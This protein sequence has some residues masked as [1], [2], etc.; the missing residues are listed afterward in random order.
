MSD[1]KFVFF[2]QG[3]FKTGEITICRE[4][5]EIQV[6]SDLEG[7]LILPRLKDYLKFLI[8]NPEWIKEF[9]NNIHI[10]TDIT[11]HWLYYLRFIPRY[12]IYYETFNNPLYFDNGVKYPQVKKWIPYINLENIYKNDIYE[13][14]IHSSNVILKEMFN[15]CVN[16]DYTYFKLLYKISK[17]TLDLLVPYLFVK[18]KIL[19]ISHQ[20][21]VR[22]FCE[23]E[24]N[25]ILCQKFK[26]KLAIKLSGL[27]GENVSLYLITSS[28]KDYLNFVNVVQELVD[29]NKVCLGQLSLRRRIRLPMVSCSTF[30][31]IFTE[32][33]ILLKELLEYLL[34]HHNLSDAYI[35]KIL[36][37]LRRLKKIY[38]Y[39]SVQ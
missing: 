23:M 4:K 29:I 13:V 28:L 6:L 18:Y 25:D 8:Y 32:N 1:V 37:H 39:I 24:N 36:D 27:S 5:N 15:W 22:K 11:I 33:M 38:P 9:E 20:E 35:V 30:R 3:S 2:Y 17:V 10:K 16:N 12:Y 34:L 7:L 26:D 14:L 31:R 19:P 21:R